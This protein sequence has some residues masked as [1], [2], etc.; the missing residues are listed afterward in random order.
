[1]SKLFKRK[2]PNTKEFW[3]DIYNQHIDQK[4]LRSDGDKLQKFLSL[5]EKAESVLDFGGGLGGNLKY[6]SSHV[7]N[8][9][10]ILVDHSEVS[11]NFVKEKLLGEKDER[12]NSFKYHTSL[13]QIP[14]NSIDM[15]MSFQVLE[16]LTEY[17]DYMD[18]LWAR[19][20][21]G[22]IMLIS[23]PVK[24]IRDRNRQHVNKF[25][26]KSMFTILS[27]YEEIVHIA[28]RTYS[29]RSGI[30]GTAYF[31]VEKPDGRPSIN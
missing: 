21:P 10:F 18:Q 17:K 31:Y 2:N 6:L 7:S 20:A 23:V 1:M 16:H 30:L 14:E 28:P 8:T 3:E 26:L 22:G 27:E 4:K 29:R 11:L 19:T 24:G 12:G 13:E 25:T 5:F 15:V 9:R